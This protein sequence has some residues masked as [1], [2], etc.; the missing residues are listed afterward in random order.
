[1]TEDYNKALCEERHCRIDEEMN[2][3]KSDHTKLVESI[4]GKFNK[5]MFGIFAVLLSIIGSLVAVL[6]T[7]P[8]VH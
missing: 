2:A 1:M 6:A 5:I 8:G 3:M 7:R 4:N